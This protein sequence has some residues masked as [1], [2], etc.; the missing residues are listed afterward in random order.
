MQR[1]CK[2]QCWLTCVMSAGEIVK[3]L[4]SAAIAAGVALCQDFAK[5]ESK[6]AN[7]RVS[8]KFREICLLSE[9]SL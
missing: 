1:Q 7:A 6:F 9:D 2:V 5:F 4:L 3:M 8:A